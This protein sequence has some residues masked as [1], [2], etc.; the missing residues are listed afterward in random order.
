MNGRLAQRAFLFMNYKNLMFFLQIQNSHSAS[1]IYF[2]LL[3]VSAMVQA[4]QSGSRC[5]ECFKIT[6]LFFSSSTENILKCFNTLSVELN[7]QTSRLPRRLI[8]YITYGFFERNNNKANLKVHPT[9]KKNN[10]I[11]VCD[12]KYCP[13]SEEV[14]PV[15]STAPMSELIR[16]PDVE[17]LPFPFKS[18]SRPLQGLRAGAHT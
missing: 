10:S 17:L 13:C 5:L 9:R 15:F 11:P 8:Y 16:W 1:F 7:M 6:S 14:P 12:Q 2:E 18:Q 3:Q 4:S